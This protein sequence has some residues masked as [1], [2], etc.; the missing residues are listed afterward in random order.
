MALSC[1]L[2]LL[3]RLYADFGRDFILT[4]A[5]VAT[6]LQPQER[7]LGGFKYSQLDA[8]ATA[9]DKPHGKIINWFNTQFY[10][11]WG[12]ASSTVGYNAIINHGYD[13]SRV[14]LG[15]L[16]SPNDGGSGWKNISTYIQTINQLRANYPTFGDVVSWEYY[17][18]GLGEQEGD[19]LDAFGEVVQG[20]GTYHN[21]P[22]TWER[23]IGDIIYGTS[24]GPG[25]K[26]NMTDW[27]IPRP[28]SPWPAATNTI[29]ALGGSW[30]DA[31]WAL[32]NTAGDLTAALD[33]LGLHLL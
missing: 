13:P 5:P 26:P 3:Q 14:L 23:S 6:D 16:D 28:E 11:G 9:A 17:D 27:P 32:N 8:Q 7:G 20:N 29:L 25:W 33:L 31:I 19:T 18:A 2:A 1:P 24:A 10:N 4:M 30:L 12:D 22:W 21:D 15:V